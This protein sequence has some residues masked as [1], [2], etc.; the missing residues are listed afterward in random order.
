MSGS[1]FQSMENIQGGVFY[2]TPVSAG[3]SIST[4]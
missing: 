4:L 2:M 3:F 1:I